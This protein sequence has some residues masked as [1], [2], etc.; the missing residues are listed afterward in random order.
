MYFCETFNVLF[1]LYSAWILNPRDFI[2]H[3]AA[4]SEMDHDIEILAEMESKTVKD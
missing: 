2:Y 1:M 3:I 4:D